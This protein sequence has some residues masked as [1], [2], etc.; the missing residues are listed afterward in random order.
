ML[1]EEALVVGLEEVA[2][3]HRVAELLAHRQRV[4]LERVRDL[5]TED[6]AR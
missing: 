4:L 1:R 2:E 3:D 5:A 6:P